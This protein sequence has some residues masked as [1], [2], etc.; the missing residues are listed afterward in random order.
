MAGG[1]PA[2]VDG[3]G[4]CYG[5]GWQNIGHEAIRLYK[6]FCERLLS[7]NVMRSVMM[8]ISAGLGCCSLVRLRMVLEAK[9]M[10]FE[11]FDV[12]WYPRVLANYIKPQIYVDAE[13]PPRPINMFAFRLVYDSLIP[14]LKLKEFLH[15]SL[16]IIK[17]RPPLST[18]TL[19]P[20]TFE[21][22][23]GTFLSRRSTSLCL[24]DFN[25]I[26]PYLTTH[27]R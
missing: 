12:H 3:V 21:N 5:G 14:I 20:V 27:G 24:I 16:K 2:F 22:A 8:I 4:R 18:E 1:P 15:S 13:G 19:I 25:C 6:G 9:I 23:I 26:F 10:Y 17:A 7:T 11:E